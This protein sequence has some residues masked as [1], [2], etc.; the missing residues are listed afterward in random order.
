MVKT[1][2]FQMYTKNFSTDNGFHAKP[3]TVPTS[4]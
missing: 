3:G 4:N 2:M 1:I